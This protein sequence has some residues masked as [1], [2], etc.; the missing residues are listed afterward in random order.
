VLFAGQVIERKGVAD[1]LRA[2]VLL[3]ADARSTAELLVVGD[4]LQHGGSYR[5]AMERL[6]RELD[7]PAR[8]LGFQRNVPQWL[9]ASD[10]AVVPSH[11]EPLGNATLEAMAHGLPV[12][13]G[14][15]GGIPEMVV[16]E[17]TGLLVPPRS[18]A[19]LAA[20]LERLLSDDPFRLHLGQ[21]ARARCVQYFSLEAHVANVVDQYRS[22]LAREA[23]CVTA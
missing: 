8:F 4:D 11:V 14:D 12:I 21:Q 10:I 19:L 18:P 17:T 6:A 20:S 1:L 5:F 16:H 13:G 3:S 2:W 23:G 7:C 22:V 9:T 15:V